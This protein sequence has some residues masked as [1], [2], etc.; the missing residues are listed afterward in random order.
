VFKSS[1]M[2]RN[3]YPR[4]ELLPV[5]HRQMHSPGKE[6]KFR[7]KTSC[8]NVQ[9]GGSGFPFLRSSSRKLRRAQLVD[10][11]LVNQLIHNCLP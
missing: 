1:Q 7:A 6:L 9:L 4:Q 5:P 11:T 10:A 2:Q 8:F 3:I